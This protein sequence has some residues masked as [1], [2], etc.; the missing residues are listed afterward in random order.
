MPG[1][2]CK[3]GDLGF[4]KAWFPPAGDLGKYVLLPKPSPETKPPPHANRNPTQPGREGE[5]GLSHCTLLMYIG[6]DPN[7]QEARGGE[8]DPNKAST[9]TTKA[10]LYTPMH[11]GWEPL[12]K[13]AQG[14]GRTESK[15]KHRTGQRTIPM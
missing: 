11:R 4:T 13:E 5:A 15:R 1:F 14:K 8:Q 10:A 7:R 6:E 9:E 2:P 12:G 3:I